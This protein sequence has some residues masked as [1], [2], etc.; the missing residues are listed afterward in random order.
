MW[1]D[2]D[3]LCNPHAIGEI[4]FLDS[5]VPFLLIPTRPQVSNTAH[6]LSWAC[7]VMHPEEETLELSLSLLNER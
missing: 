6:S 2:E 5:S 3:F 1:P 4:C 7:A